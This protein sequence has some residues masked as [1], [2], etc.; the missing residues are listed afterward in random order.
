MPPATTVAVL[1]PD[2][3]KTSDVLLEFVL[4]TVGCTQKFPSWTHTSAKDGNLVAT[5]KKKH[6]HTVHSSIVIVDVIR[7]HH[8]WTIVNVGLKKKY[9]KTSAPLRSNIRYDGAQLAR[10]LAR[11][12]LLGSIAEVHNTGLTERASALSS[13]DHYC[14]RTARDPASSVLSGGLSPHRPLG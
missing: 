11:Q 13:S 6:N 10:T 9:K 3:S 12:G 8:H 4:L 14:R 2:S 5:P 1:S 7:R